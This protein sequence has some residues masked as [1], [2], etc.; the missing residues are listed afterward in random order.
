MLFAGDHVL[1]TI[2]PSIGFEPTSPPDPLGDF[3]GS[4]A[5]L[6][7][8]PDAT[9]LP[10]HGPVVPSVHRRIDELVEHHGRRLDLTEAAVH[11]GA[12]TAY[13]VAGLLRWTRRERRFADLDPFNQMLAVGETDAHLRLLAAQGRVVRQAG[14]DGV[15]RFA[16]PSAG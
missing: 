1:P 10:A 3:L 9:L 8:L 13:E 15:N 16:D 5:T 4:L 12:A 14:D 7:A 2:T 11:R 6:R